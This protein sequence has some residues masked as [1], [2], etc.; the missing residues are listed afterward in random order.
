MSGDVSGEPP[1]RAVG[2]N[3]DPAMLKPT[4]IDAKSKLPGGGR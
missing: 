3:V 4:E 2:P 1:D